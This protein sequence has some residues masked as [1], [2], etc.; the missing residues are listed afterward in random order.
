MPSDF[1]RKFNQLFIKFY[2]H[3]PGKKK[4]EQQNQESFLAQKKWKNTYT[5]EKKS[6]IS[7][8]PVASTENIFNMV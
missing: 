2:F 8:F 4:I 3:T 7:A 1:Y 6:R 5:W